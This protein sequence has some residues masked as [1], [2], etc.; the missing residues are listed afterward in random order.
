LHFELAAFHLYTQ[1]LD[2]LLAAV[3]LALV[4]LLAAVLLE[5]L[6]FRLVLKA[7]LAL[8]DFLKV[9]PCLDY[10]LLHLNHQLLAAVLKA[11]VHQ[12]LA[13]VLEALDG[14][15]LLRLLHHQKPSF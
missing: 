7:S 4:C 3:L 11:F 15:N 9:L 1:A 6:V 5:A 2:D 13:A 14:L 10:F 12:L 8:L